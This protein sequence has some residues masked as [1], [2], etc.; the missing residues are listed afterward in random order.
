MN[1]HPTVFISY[2]R[3]DVRQVDR[4]RSGLADYGIDSWMD[5]HS[6]RPGD[7]WKTAIRQAIQSG[8]HFIACFSR[9]YTER[10]ST[11][12][13]EELVLAI[14]EVRQ[15]LPTAPWFLPVL[16]SG[17]VPDIDIGAGR[18]L[19]DIEHVDLRGD[20]N[21]TWDDG[22]ARL[23]DR[24][25]PGATSTT[26]ESLVF[27]IPNDSAHANAPYI[28]M[29]RSTY[30]GTKALDRAEEVAT[31]TEGRL[32]EIWPTLAQPA[33]QV[34][35]LVADRPYLYGERSGFGVEELKM[36]LA[37]HVGHTG[38]PGD[39]FDPII[40]LFRRC[41]DQDNEPEFRVWYVYQRPVKA[42]VDSLDM[43]SL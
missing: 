37:R 12:M 9:A 35:R 13:N 6:L 38:E 24:I 2:V 20:R 36:C 42:V 25:V 15:R 19:C 3:E 29:D 11:Y 4:L 5:R 30:I 34:L 23:A 32:R 16:L 10:L 17:D 22:I 41:F 26:I 31:I 39:V 40:F 8:T 7:F 1:R 43:K 28:G 18:S 33:R 27:E 21:D 14:E